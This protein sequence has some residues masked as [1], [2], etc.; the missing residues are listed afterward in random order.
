[1]IRKANIPE[2]MNAL[3][4]HGPHDWRYEEIPV[5]VISEDEI[6][7]KIEACGICASD[8]KCFHGAPMYWGDEKNM[9]W[10]KEPVV[11][12]HEFIG[13]V[14][15]IGD[16]A[17]RKY[18]V[19]LGDR[20]ISEQIVPCWECRFCKSGQHWM[21]VNQD[22]HGYHNDIG[23][24]A[25][26]EYL[27]LS[28]RDVVHKVSKD[29]PAAYAAMIEPLSCAVHSVERAQI[30]FNDVVAIAG[31]GPIG[32]CKLQLA[33]LKNPKMVIAI[34]IKE[35]R[36]AVAKEYGADA[37]LNCTKTDVVQEVLDLT[38][39]YGCDVYINVAGVQSS[40]SNGL[41]MLRKKGRYVEFSIYEKDIATNWNIIGDRKELDIYGSHIGGQDGYT[42][43][44]DLLEKGLI[45]VSK[46]VTHV[47]PL[48]RWEEGLDL[49][50]TARDGAIKVVLKP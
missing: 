44:I 26:A 31:C 10:V 7:L 42:V 37:V 34:D 39:G 22:M 12:G 18:S 1:M 35:D 30:H 33:K 48:T 49:A 11:T 50:M 5:P 28:S 21:C 47:L 4:V 29:I 25:M 9:K 24:G 27:R 45:D 2:K 17:R 13:V 40:N 3:V 41:Q 38:D 46:L 43:A 15:A 32:L 19:D 23:E 36:L 8:V 6:L 16:N 14:A 20:V